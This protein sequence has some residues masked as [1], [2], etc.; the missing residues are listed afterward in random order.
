M[1]MNDALTAANAALQA[2][3]DECVKGK[4]DQDAV[5]Q[6]LIVERDKLKANC[7]AILKE[8]IAALEADNPTAVALEA[9]IQQV[10]TAMEVAGPKDAGEG[11]AVVK[12]T[13]PT[14]VLPVG[15]DTDQSGGRRKGGKRTRLYKKR[16]KGFQNL[17]NYLPI[18]F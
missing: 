2:K 11:T 13:P 7:D 6:E 15:Q 16:V 5:V 9:L 3:Y 10:S 12:E 4:G 18:Y 14:E 8:I 17:Q 1:D